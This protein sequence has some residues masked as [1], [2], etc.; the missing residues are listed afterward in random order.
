MKTST[1]VG[2]VAAAVL[3]LFLLGAATGEGRVLENAD[4]VL[5]NADRVLENADRVLE[6]ADRVLENA[7]RVLE[8]EG[9]VREQPDRRH[10]A[11]NV[12]FFVG[13]GMGVSTV[14]ATRVA[15]VGV[16]GQ[17]AMDKFPYTAL[18]RT[19]TSD[20]ITP[21]SA[22]T[23][24]AMMTGVNTNSGVMGFGPKTEP[25]DFNK[26]GDGEPVINLVE[27]AVQAGMKV[28]VVSTTRV[29]H[30]TPAACYAHTNNR[31]L[32]NK[33][34]LQALPSDA[35]YNKRL[36]GGVD[37]LM[38]GGRRHFL[39]SDQEDEEGEAGARA[40]RRDL[41]KEFQSAG[42]HYF[43]NKTGFDAVTPDDLP[44]LGL[45]ENS[46]MEYE[47]DRATDTG[48][49]PGI[50]E[51]TTKSIELLAHATKGKDRGYFLMVEGGRIDHAHHAGNAFRSIMDTKAFD[52]AIA[53]AVN[54][55]DLSDTLIIVT[56]D[57]SH[58]FTMA[59]YPVVEASKMPYAYKSA[60]PEYEKSP[61]GG[62]FDIVFALNRAGAIV[63]ATDAAGVPYT[64][65]GYHNGPGHRRV[66]SPGAA[67]VDP[68]V[69]T[70]PGPRG[71]I[72]KGPNDPN[73]R[74]ESAIPL[75]SET[76][77]A[78]DVVIYAI[79]AGANAVH[80]TVKNTFVHD[81]M[82]NALGL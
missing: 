66:T 49:E 9:R 13:D 74:Q 10:P 80:G 3:G 6:N 8:N 55:V 65:F 16:D 79:G 4:R 41:R 29:T 50:R 76:H 19:Y 22:G 20:H 40:D 53:A 48:G 39:P 1:A 75:G 70:F 18:S 51:M 81:V 24:S 31:N 7:D 33:I 69:D 11:R 52:D 30:A 82:K 32:E 26:D 23:M 64:M 67:R 15:T 62:A 47:H 42:Y 46:H 60:P 68:C 17:L 56:A 73:Y 71:D 63:K 21:D 57:H 28:G 78:E 27:R 45:L 54:T 25:G 44:I 77:G 58:V 72:P 38:G 12:I 34:I 14:T 61:H 43:W 35:T 2:M 37:I 5:E 59:G 36:G